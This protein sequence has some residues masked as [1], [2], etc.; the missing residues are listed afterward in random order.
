MLEIQ[1][2]KI[3]NL[4]SGSHMMTAKRG[5]FDPFGNTW[6]GGADGALIELNAKAKRIE[7][8]WPPIAP[9]PY[10]DFYEAYPD[11]NGDIWA[12]VLHG[13]QM[14]R[15]DPKTERW[16][17]YQMPEPYSYDRRTIIDASTKPV[18]VWYV[19][20]N[21]YLVRVQPLE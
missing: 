1:T 6:W 5:G 9:H 4:N 8:F 12:G 11:K 7:E 21:N 2:G 14:L 18:T 3:L 17:V 15:L 13:R 16:R 20:Y 19:D 10:T